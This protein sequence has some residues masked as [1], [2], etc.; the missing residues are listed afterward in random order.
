MESKNENKPVLARKRFSPA[1]L[2]APCD[3]SAPMPEHL[4]EFEHAKLTDS[5]MM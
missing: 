4:L 1:E 5:E 3:P 2:N